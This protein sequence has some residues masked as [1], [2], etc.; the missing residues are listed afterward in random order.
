MK[1]TL[2]GY[3]FDEQDGE[4]ACNGCPLAGSCKMVRCPNCG[5]DVILEP[6]LIK[7]YKKW[8]KDRN[9]IRRKS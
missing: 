7:T 4:N 1:C 6:K 8:R 2:C 9:G 5:Y 3:E